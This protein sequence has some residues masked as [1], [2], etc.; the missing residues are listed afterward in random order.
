MEIS[1]CLW[2]IFAVIG[3]IKI[4]CYLI[5][6]LYWTLFS[7]IS[8]KNYQYG[9][10]LIT[11]ATDGIGKAISKEFVRRNFK[12]I[13]VSR[14]IEKLENVKS[15]LLSLYPHGVIEV[16]SADFSFSHKDPINF[17]SDLHNKLSGFPIS[18]L[19][20]N[21]GVATVKMLN[22]DVLE[23]I[24]SMLGVNIYPSTM[25]THKLVPLFLERY[26]ETKQKSLVINV[27]STMEESIFPGN[28]VYSATKRY[29]AFFSEGLRYEYTGKIDF[30]TVKPGLVIT[31]LVLRN[32]TQGLPLST[33]TDTFAQALLGGLRTGTNHAHWKH[34]ILGTLLRIPPYQF[35]IFLVRC[36]L[37]SAV[38][39][40]IIS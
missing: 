5:P 8:L 31:P 33:D 9:Y 38:K 15:E 35:T 27:S 39:K 24:E 21:V 12:V 30:V 1:T 29:N 6:L 13:L 20:N 26:Q 28:A 18:V 2:H 3:A 37:P 32:N 16:I 11:G 40:G 36:A 7:C 25:I 34:K 10:V 19:V 14:S 22:N 4:A 17:Y 23:N